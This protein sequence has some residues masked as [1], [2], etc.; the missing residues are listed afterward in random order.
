MTQED[1]Q[2]S[3][4]VAEE[5]QV[6]GRTVERKPSTANL[7]IISRPTPILS[8]WLVSM[9]VV[10]NFALPQLPSHGHLKA[11]FLSPY[12]LNMKI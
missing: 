5:L 1:L 4:A 10:A 7:L 9:I 3:L 12:E 8:R 2:S 6:K 11:S